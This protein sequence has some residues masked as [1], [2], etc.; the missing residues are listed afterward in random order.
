MKTSTPV[1]RLLLWLG[2]LILSAPICLVGAP[3]VA[4]AAEGLS[5]TDRATYAAAFA[6]ADQGRWGEARSL[7]A[8]AQDKT[9]ADVILWRYLRDPDQ[10]PDLDARLSFLDQHANWPL[11]SSI[12]RLA[13]LEFYQRPRSP[14]R[15][16]AFFDRHPPLSP[17]GRIALARAYLE[18]GDRTKAKE[19]ARSAWIDTDFWGNLDREFLRI[20]GPLLTADDQ[21]AR[22]DR[23]VWDGRYDEARALLPRLS[24]PHAAL[25]SA[26]LVL[27]TRQG[28]ADA[29]VAAVPASLRDDPGLVF[30]RIRWRRRA[31]LDASA[32]Q[33][34][35]EQGSTHGREDR[36]WQERAI[37]AR[38]ALD[39]GE[40]ATAYRLAAGHE[41]DA[42]TAFAEGEWMAGWIALRFQNA[43][44]RALPHFQTLYDGVSTPISRSRGAYWAG[45]AAEAQ[46]QGDA[47]R[48]WYTRATEHPTTFY[49]QLAAARLGIPLGR[50]IPA[51]DPTPKAEEAE[52]LAKDPRARIARQLAALGRDDELLSFVLA[53]TED[54]P[55][56]GARALVAR[57]A[58]EA[59]QPG[60]AVSFAR[61]AALD[62]TVLVEGGYPLPRGLAE[63]ITAQA[64]AVGLA[65]AAAFG[66]IRQESSFDPDARSSAGALG[67]MQLMPTTAQIV[68]RQENVAYDLARLTRDPAYNTQLGTR[69][70]GD[71]MA[72]FGG[73]VVLA[74][75]GYN[76]GPGRPV[77]WMEANG[78]PRRM[79]PDAAIDWIEKIPFRE[80]RNYVQ[81]VVEGMLVYRLRLGETLAADAP[82]RAITR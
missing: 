44:A 56:P 55:G 53:L 72:R 80:T 20:L 47:A 68:A 29:A 9:L 35:I 73:A 24:P 54:H 34:L 2:G 7:A 81:R 77:Q 64:R 62:G 12:Q 61:R 28:D 58:L 60:V 21:Y 59:G 43:P 15:V 71:L 65:P 10:R 52:A 31:G 6:A 36:W 41:H 26:R 66:V 78:D 1:L 48:A 67:L 45:R 46:G 79:S 11:V 3:A 17:T 38:D 14:D 13:E 27:A 50:L 8:S 18:Q 82:D 74:A 19:T 4:V 37:L 40:V 63:T 23:L 70:L 16:I 25:I 33:L 30:E 69:Y 22:A 32:I 76:A 49:G 51:Q 75:A 5:A 42:G 57:T 39:R